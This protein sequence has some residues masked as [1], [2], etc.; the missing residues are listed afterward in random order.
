MNSPG[1]E[2]IP[3][4]QI[5]EPSADLK[6]VLS[7]LYGS[8]QPELRQVEDVLSNEL[9]SSYP[10]VEEIVRYGTR[11]GGK[12]LRPALVLLAGQA[13]GSLSE[14]HVI[15]AAVVE[16][17]HLATLV[18]DDVLDEATIRRHVDT[19]NTRWN[20]ETSVLLGD[21]LFTHAFYLAST[22]ESTYACR[23]I[24]QAT[25]T[26]CEGELRQTITRG[27]LQLTEEHYLEIVEAK[28][29]E[30]CACC[31]QLGAYY[32]GANPETVKSLS[33]FGRN[34]GTAFQI[35]DDILDLKGSEETTGKSL[36]TDLTKC[37]LTLPLIHARDNI[38]P[39]KRQDLLKMMQRSNT[40]DRAKIL[41]FLAEL[42][43]A[44]Y[45]HGHAQLYVDRA[46]AC[47]FQLEE[48]PAKDTLQAMADFVISRN[49]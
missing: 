5:R 40:S 1:E 21:F 31:C 34:L 35:A 10:E 25:N 22:T 26:V 48:S 45:A 18:H 30:L 42:D 17:V 15:L 11:L 44:A 36:G 14:A 32:A 38:S 27:N 6:Q 49:A 7:T 19:V 41:N 24:G 4:S 2:R 23:T 16:M 29:A 3:M 33:E 47:L 28:T 13:S 43:S 12:R 9:N 37:K 8:I 39:E 20:N 46:T